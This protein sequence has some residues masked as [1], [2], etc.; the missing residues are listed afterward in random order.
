MYDEEYFNSEEF[1]EILGE[2][3]RSIQAGI[4]PF[5]DVDDLADVADYYQAHERYD[6]AVAAVDRAL[7]LSPGATLPL[8]FKI[9]DA[10]S[11][12]NIVAAEEYLSQIENPSDVEAQY[13]AAEVLIAQDRI[14]EADQQFR[15]QMKDIDPDEHQDFVIDVASIY[16]DY[17][18]FD[19]AMEW[20]MRGRQ[21]NTDDFKELM[22]RTLFGLGKYTD[23]ER[24][25]NELI[26]NNPFQKR[27]WNALASAQFMQEDYG[28]SITSSEYAIAIDPD[29]PEGLLAKANGLFRLDNIEE[30]LNYYR[31][32]SERVPDDEFG[33]LHQGTCLISQEHYTEAAEKL[34]EALKVAPHD[35]PYLADIYQELG[36]AYSE[37]HKPDTA[38]YYLEQ[39]DRLDDCDH[40]DIYV[41]KGHVLLA[42]Q[43]VKEAEEMFRRA[44][45]ESGN[46]PKTMLRVM[47]SL[48]DNLYIEAA[49][50]MF[51][52]FF[53]YVNDDWTDGYAYMALCCH[54][55]R[56]P[57]EF[58]HYLQLATERNP[59]EARTV[60][61]HLFP[62]GMKPEQYLDYIIAQQKK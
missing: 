62:E 18:V 33:L 10:I 58:L 19:K 51:K 15:K 12:G 43:R 2:Y 53:E 16:S 3:E 55:L 61:G 52:H 24:I 41:V 5:M 14:D 39:T 57:K 30:A 22:A 8:V 1:S 46:S 34:E 17:G 54:D 59:K 37:L 35:S 50:K 11:Q 13:A 49:Y 23:S 6:D 20:M 47:V 36:F 56:K 60:L 29:D 38:I 25:F 7:E 28:A 44:V 40:A 27:Y 45:S 31:R 32:Y 21:E 4:A 42:N 26:D 9:R 48:Y